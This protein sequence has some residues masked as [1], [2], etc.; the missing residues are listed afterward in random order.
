VEQNNP[1]LNLYLQKG[2]RI[3]EDK[4]VYFEM[5]WTDEDNNA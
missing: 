4:G 1:A 3:I 2:F 5:E